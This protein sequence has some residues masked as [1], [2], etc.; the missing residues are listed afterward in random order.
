MVVGYVLA[1]TAAAATPKHRRADLAA[2]GRYVAVHDVAWR[3]TDGE[4][5]LLDEY[6]PQGNGNA[7]AAVV[8][9]HGGAW[10][11]G[12]KT[13]FGEQGARL[14]QAGFVA[15]SVT[16]R[17]AP[18]HPWPA[19]L[20][21]VRAAVAWLRAP[22]QV[23]ELGIDPHRIGMIGGSAG[24][25]LAGLIGTEGT[26]A[27]DRGSRVAVVVSWSGL[28]DMVTI[29]TPGFDADLFDC[30]D[31]GCLGIA[32]DASPMTHVD[33]TDA[34]MLLVNGSNDPI[35]HASQATDMAAVLASAGV[36][37][38]ILV[39]PGPA[40]SIQLSPDAWSTTLAFLTKH[41]AR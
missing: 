21:D 32:A 41:L 14:A 36:D 28:M 19:Q 12:D 31:L 16:Y 35:V 22:E 8:L 7:R 25:Q 33:A 37:H 4:T 40:H 34:P 2:T 17:L 11:G 9:V 3:T 10:Q 18:E 20:D 29:E 39:V 26:G 30:V 27:L 38:D 24:G 5:L 23:R 6:V 1:A 15:V 13:E